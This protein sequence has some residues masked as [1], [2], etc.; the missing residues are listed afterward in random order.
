MLLLLHS[1]TFSTAMNYNKAICY[2]GYLIC[3]L[4]G[5]TTHCSSRLFFF[6]HVIK[7]M[8][9]TLFLGWKMVW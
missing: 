7:K 9:K 5:V 1:C 6:F 4:K 2:A 8:S 3:S